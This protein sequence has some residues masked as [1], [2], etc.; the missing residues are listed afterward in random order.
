MN[1]HISKNSFAVTFM[2]ACAMT[3]YAQ[4]I[5][6]IV[7]YVPIEKDTD[8]ND[9]YGTIILPESGLKDVAICNNSFLIFKD[10]KNMSYIY[11]TNT[12]QELT[13]AKLN[14]NIAY[15]TEKG[16]LVGEVRKLFKKDTKPTSYNF[17]NKPLWICDKTAAYLANEG[18]CICYLQDSPKKYTEGNMVAY[19]IFT[20]KELWRKNI[21]HKYHYPWLECIKKNDDEIYVIA[22]SLLLLNT[23]TGQTKS[24]PFEAGVKESIIKLGSKRLLAN[25]KWELEKLSAT[26]PQIDANTIAG[27][28]SNMI[29][30]SD[31][32]YIADASKLY[33]FTK[34]LKLIWQ[35]LIPEDMASSSSIY[36]YNDTIVMQNYGIGFMT[37][38]YSPITT[39]CGI[40]FTAA[41]DAKTGKQL[42]LNKADNGYKLIG[43][44]ITPGRFYWQDSKYFYYNDFG[45]KEI[46]RLNWRKEKM[47]LTRKSA[48]EPLRYMVNK[49]YTV[50]KGQ[51]DSIC[52]DKNHLIFRE[53]DSKIYIVDNNEE[54]KELDNQNLFFKI[55]ANILSSI[56]EE[57]KYKYLLTDKS[58]MK[59]KRT[60][61]T[62]SEFN[63]DK[64]GNIFILAKDG[65]G[66]I[67]TNND[68]KTNFKMFAP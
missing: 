59:V 7:Q 26:G 48:A 34:D 60:V 57:G 36:K 54:I 61:V 28:H 18:T 31:R 39:K 44:M 58:G 23:R 40:P 12:M 38:I 15:I 45:E 21:P 13:R 64:N 53:Y 25:T 67:R 9:L 32:I 22:D 33:C 3:L 56:N 24:V 19:D 10:K 43:G 1:F 4:D 20:G 35:T 16:Y 42:F 6:R 30:E 5:V 51:I 2:L 50:N 68:Y 11:N 55:S 41:F 65:I 63:T 66:I 52:S 47:K 29:S 27:T 49:L 17:D 37:T 46:H 8:G 14:S 62:D